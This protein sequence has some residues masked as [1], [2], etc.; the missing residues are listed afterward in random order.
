MAQIAM[1]EVQPGEVPP[2][3]GT[4]VQE[5]PARPVVRGT[6]GDDYV[7]V[8]CGNVLAATLA[9]EYVNRKFRVK[10]ARCRTVNVGIEVEGVDYTKAF[11]GSRRG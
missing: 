9:P 11:A 4:A 6:G 3:G 10:C 7:C 8:V 2:D 5:E 1:Q